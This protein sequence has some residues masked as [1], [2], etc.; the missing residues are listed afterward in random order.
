MFN[1]W[2]RHPLGRTKTVG[3]TGLVQSG[4]TVLLT[5]LISH[6]RNHSPGRLPI[7]GN[8]TQVTEVCALPLPPGSTPFDVE[9]Y[10]E[11][12][13]AHRF[14]PKTLTT[15]EFRAEY[16]RSDWSFTRLALHLIEVPGELLADSIVATHPRFDD[17]SDAVL[18][19]LARHDFARLTGPF[20]DALE[21]SSDQDASTGEETL[22]RAYRTALARMV[23]AYM[24]V[25][26]PSSFLPRSP[27][28][29]VDST[30]SEDQ[31]IAA[32]VD[33]QVC[34]LDRE[35]QF[36]PLSAAQRVKSA[37]ILER[38]RQ[39]YTAYRQE[40]VLPMARRLQRCDELIVLVDV[41]ML[42]EGGTGMLN[43][44]ALFL[45]QL[46]QA[47]DPGFRP[48]AAVLNGLC[49]V[50]GG[51]TPFRG[52]RRLTFVATKADRVHPTDRGNLLDLLKDLV[53]P[54]VGRIQAT[55]NLQID[56]H[57]CAAVCC[58]RCPDPERHVL[59]HPAA[60]SAV[61]RPPSVV[62]VDVS[63]VPAEWPADFAPGDYV[64]ADPAPWMP[65][66]LVRVP[67]QIDLH[68]IAETILS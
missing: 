12:L 5:S 31:R 39:H 41:A 55:R 21:S 62:E 19:V 2:N 40:I 6:L 34:G 17:W 7:G 43:A 59:N 54:L 22:H 50:L 26:T 16:V 30:A 9:R 56:Y 65:K 44:N 66:A 24:P 27:L 61:D 67:D 14:P 1:P 4:K 49:R 23:L 33:Q 29:G 42:L 63:S 68:R 37:S 28:E 38:F 11:D 3:I 25:V 15:H 47:V 60:A 52:I 10:R 51:F 35:R 57:L 32:L 13:A 48:P 53:R 64:F 20:L 45:E 8:G 46:L 58:T 18:R 36:F